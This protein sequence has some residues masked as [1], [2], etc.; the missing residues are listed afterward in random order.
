MFV[1][2]QTGHG[3]QETLD[4]LPGLPSVVGLCIGT[5]Q[6]VESCLYCLERNKLNRSHFKNF[7]LFIFCNEK[8]SKGS[9]GLKYLNPRIKCDVIHLQKVPE[10]TIW[11]SKGHYDF[12][13]MV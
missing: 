13:I 2:F 7:I 5:L 9:I 8:V 6:T 3:H 1:V 10:G 12:F 4:D 11:M